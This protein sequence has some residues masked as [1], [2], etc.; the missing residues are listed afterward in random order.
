MECQWNKEN[1]ANEQYHPPHILGI[2]PLAAMVNHSCCGNAVRTYANG[3]M[4]VHASQLIT[5]GSEVVWS[6]IPPTKGFMERRRI[7]KRN[8]RF[9]CK[10]ERCMLE[11]AELS[12]DILPLNYKNVLQQCSRWN[13]MIV[14]VNL[15]EDITRQQI[16]STFLNLQETVLESNSLSTATTRHLR[17]GFTNLHFNYFNISLSRRS[18]SIDKIVYDSILNS[19]THLHFSFCGSNN[20]STEHVSLLHLCY[21]ISNILMCRSTSKSDTEVNRKRIKFYTEA[22]KKLHMI[23]YGCLGSDIE[24]VRA[25]LVHTRTVLRSPNGYTKIKH[26]FL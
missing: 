2:F 20:A 4:A 12:R 22:I 19:A 7:L 1:N 11:S 14:D 16:T 18:S 26:D 5:I 17:V 15:I 24:A 6:Y 23:R 13:E 10:C 3:V 9:L 25:C 8:H 21:D